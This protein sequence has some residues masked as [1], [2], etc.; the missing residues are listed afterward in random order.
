ME[1]KK[2]LKSEPEKRLTNFEWQ[3]LRKEVLDRDNGICVKCKSKGNVVDHIL[4]LALGGKNILSN[5]QIL[6]DNCNL[7]KTKNDHARIRR[8]KIYKKFKDW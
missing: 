4:P 2:A 8:L 7:K 1:L 3:K 6:C 5:L